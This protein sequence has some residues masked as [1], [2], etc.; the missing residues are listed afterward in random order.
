MVSNTPLQKI[1]RGGNNSALGR[2]KVSASCIDAICIPPTG[3]PAVGEVVSH[4]VEEGNGRLELV[5]VT[6]RKEPIRVAIHFQR[7]RQRH[8]GK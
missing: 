2:L 8:D 7:R 5:V 4:D 1:L 3:I 6:G